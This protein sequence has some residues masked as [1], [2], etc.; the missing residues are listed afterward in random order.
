ML[1][2]YQVADALFRM[3]H[4]PH[5][6]Q[7]ASMHNKSGFA[8]SEGYMVSL[9]GCEVRWS[10]NGL[11]LPSLGVLDAWAHAVVANVIAG[12]WYYGYWRDE[13][14]GFIYLDASVNIASY[15]GAVAYAKANK[16][17]AIYDVC[18]KKSIN[19]ERLQV[20]PAH[21]AP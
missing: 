13:E 1:K 12:D 5:D 16:Q 11:G 6:N 14:N 10:H 19:V 8:P 9:Q 18:H 3:M 15:R 17:L 20:L 4:R 21:I 7:G 2:P